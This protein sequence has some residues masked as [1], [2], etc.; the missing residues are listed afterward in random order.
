MLFILCLITVGF[1]TFGPPPIQVQL[2]MGPLRIKFLGPVC[3]VMHKKEGMNMTPF[4]FVYYMCAITAFDE[5][6]THTV[7]RVMEDK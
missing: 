5:M 1:L 6:C 7:L 3:S 2:G 4:I